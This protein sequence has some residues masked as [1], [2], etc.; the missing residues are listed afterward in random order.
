MEKKKSRMQLLWLIPLIV[1]TIYIIRREQQ[2]PY[3]NI[4]GLIFGTVYHVT[5][6]YDGDLKPEIEKAFKRFDASL[7]MFND[8]SVISRINQNKEVVPDTFFINVFKRSMEI[9]KETNGAFDITVAP[10]VNAWGFGFEKNKQVDSLTIDSL[11][12]II[13]YRKIAL[14]DG[15]IVKQDPRMM[16]DCSAIAKGYASDIIAHLLEKNGVKNYMVEIGGEIVAKGH[17]NKK[18]AWRIGINKPVDDSLSQNQ[19]LQNIL[20]L[21]NVGMATSGNY[22]NFYYKDGKKYA[23]TIDPATGYPVQHN[24]L[25]ATVVAQDCM[26]ADALAT[27]FMVMGLEKAEAFADM[28]PEIEACFIYSDQDGKLKNYF[29]KKMKK[30]VVE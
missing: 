3:N 27:A 19:E 30:Y 16:L 6:Q 15:K 2:T 14:K 12:K 11:R 29:T 5:Y 22:R 26:T 18:E 23:H 9:S 10:L 24:L 25:S 8:T 1:G 28:H 17:N 13:G 4:E 21:T 20:Q 7:S